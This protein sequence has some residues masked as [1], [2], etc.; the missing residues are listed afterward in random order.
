MLLTRPTTIIVVLATV[1]PACT[2]NF[3]ATGG[4]SAGGSSTSTSVSS[5]GAGSGGGAGSSI[6]S[7]GGGTDTCDDTDADGD[8][9]SLCDADCDDA[10][11]FVHPS[12]LEICGDGADEDCDG[13]DNAGDECAGYTAY[14][15]MTGNP[16]AKCTI[17]DPC[18]VVSEAVAVATAWGHP[19]A[20]LVSGGAYN[21]DVVVTGSLSLVGG[22]DPND[23]NKR[24]P[25]A[26]E[27]TIKSK[28][29]EGVRLVDLGPEMLVDGFKIVGRPVNMGV[30]S[31][32]ALAIDGGGPVVSNC[33]IRG[34]D[35]TVGPG[36]SVGVSVF[37]Q[38]ATATKPRLWFD[39]I[40]S[41]SVTAGPSYGLVVD[42]PT[43]DL[44]LI[45][46]SVTSSKGTDSVALLI[47]DSNS[48]IA[49]RDALQSGTAVGSAQPSVSLGLW[50]KRGALYFD[51]GIV[52]AD[53]IMTPPLCFTPSV[54]CG[55]ARISTGAAIL[56]NNILLG[57]ASE[58]SAAI[59][60]LEIDDDLSNVVV[61]SNLVYA[62]GELSVE[63]VS[64]AVL[65]GSPRADPVVTEV[66]RF[67]D[68]IFIGGTA[69]NNYA[70]YEQHTPGE[71]CDP[72]ALDHDLFY[73]PVVDPNE[74]R[75]Y[76]D[77]DG[78]NA[79]DLTTL[80]ELPG[81]G[82]HVQGDPKYK[83]G[84]LQSDSPCRNAGTDLDAPTHD[85]DQDMR[86]QEGAYDIGPDEFVAN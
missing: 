61:T 20:I 14:V 23:W 30:D 50:A 27:T 51:S 57:S 71:S 73:F 86:P 38:A 3:V 7:G 66:G 48:V 72:A 68:N 24:D 35:V 67:R 46:S 59:H 60:L 58:R 16:G 37:A 74:G 6:S 52:N 29:A 45:G 28:V 84:H 34:G 39:D 78:N 55:G 41:G 62:A 33:V 15:S 11:P 49:W 69:T 4:S 85:L 81:D 80:A 12:A 79:S 9:Y 40:E 43:A 47:E 22:Y 2:E 63:S 8:G 18:S 83:D 36:K 1:L 17:L 10:N 70:I 77:W 76:S 64:A 75:L 53:Q 19:A 56:S 42:A 13:K 25:K 65:L 5:G 31:S 44:Q 21:E 54:W 82:S 32:V 26:F